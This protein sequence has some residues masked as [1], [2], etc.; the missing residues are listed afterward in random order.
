MRGGN[1]KMKRKWFL[2]LTLILAFSVLA[3]G[4]AKKKE[5]A[6]TDA[7]APDKTEAPAPDKTDAP[8]VKETEKPDEPAGEA[9]E[10]KIGVL[11]PTTGPEAYYGKDMLNSY[12]MAVDEINE[13]GGFMGG[14]TFV[15]APEDDAC[16]PAQAATAASKILSGDPDFIVGGYCSGATI[17]ALQQFFDADKVM[18]ISAANSTNITDL[19]LNQSFMINSPGTHGVQTLTKLAKHLEVTKIA[20]IHQG[21]DY[22]KNLSDIVE[23]DMPGDGFEVVTVQVMEKQAPDVSAIVTAIRNAGAELVYWCG[24]HADGSNVI[25][26]LRQGG[27]EGFIVCG[28]GSSSVDLITGSG[29]A[30]EGVYVTSPPYVELVEGG[31]EYVAKYEAKYGLPPGGYSTLAY[32]TIYLLKDAIEKAG[33]IEFEAV[34]DTLQ[35]IEYQGMSG[36]I[37]FADNR[38]LAESNF[39][40]VQ[41]TDGK[42][43]RIDLP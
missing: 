23:R 33:T 21:D 27:Y 15:L 10:L 17:P 18:L 34:R 25:K 5:P 22:T 6:K 4:C 13:A 28:D 11:V 12:Q 24:Y 14:Y 2:L 8:D 36:L 31:E 41:I 35:N 40:I 26:Q 3:M 9:R 32:D 38:E 43:V 42:F 19:N 20:T 39:M 7:P 29:P 30:G 16:D 37:K 1:C